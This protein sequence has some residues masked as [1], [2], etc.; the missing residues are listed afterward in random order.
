MSLYSSRIW[1]KAHTP[2][3]YTVFDFCCEQDRVKF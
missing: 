3:A 2:T 1:I